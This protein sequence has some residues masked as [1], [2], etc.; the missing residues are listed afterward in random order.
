[1]NKKNQSKTTETTKRTWRQA[2]RF[3]FVLVRAWLWAD[4]YARVRG[5]SFLESFLPMVWHSD[6]S[7]HNEI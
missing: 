2:A 4:A 3:R 6:K 5:S 7:A 1:M